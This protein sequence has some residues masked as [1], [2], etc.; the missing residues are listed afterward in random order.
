MDDKP[1]KE[2]GKTEIDWR[3]HHSTQPYASGKYSYEDYAPAYH[4][5]HTAY[6]KHAGKD[7]DEIED[8]I[9]LDYEKNQPGSPLPWDEARPAVRSAWDKLAGTLSPRDPT[10]G[11]RSGF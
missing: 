10:R 4:T 1:A 8:D 6:E 7:F 2:P 11:I 3:E 9:A 5:A